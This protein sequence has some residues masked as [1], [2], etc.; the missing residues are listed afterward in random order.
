MSDPSEHSSTEL[1][2]IGEFAEAA[3][4]NLRTLRYYEE[5]GLLLPARRSEGGFR[6][7]RPAD[8]HRVRLI[9]GL[10]DLGLALDRIGELLD[11]RDLER[12]GREGRARWIARIRQ[13]L[14][15][16]QALIDERIR[17]LEEQR[18]NLKAAKAKLDNCAECDHIPGAE[19]NFCQPCQRTGIDLP[20]YLSALF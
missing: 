19:N 12:T 8:V 7:Y 10:Q 18:T 1:W 11:T 6:Y 13:A 14:S 3:E 9:R 15:D 16:H 20:A 2:K 5:I 4:T 17:L